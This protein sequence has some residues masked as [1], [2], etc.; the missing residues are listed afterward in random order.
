MKELTQYIDQINFKRSLFG[1][2]P[3]ELTNDIVE[4]RETIEGEGQPAQ[5]SGDGEYSIDETARRTNFWLDAI[6]QLNE[7]EKELA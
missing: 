5:L 4:I 2:A 7:Y 3:V 6:T 1:K